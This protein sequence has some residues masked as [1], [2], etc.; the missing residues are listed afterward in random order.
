MRPTHIFLTLLL[1]SPLLAQQQTLFLWPNGNPE[2]SAVVGPEIDPTTDANRIVSGKITI[3]VTNVSKPSLA[4]YSPDPAKN[5]GAAALVFPGGAYIRLAYNI[6]GTEVCDW[7]NSIGMTCVLV[8]YRVPEVGH[9]PE[10]V[11]DLE[12]AQQAMRLTR[13]H[14][15][16]WHID[17]NR[18]GVIGFS[19]GA[20]LAAVLGTHPDFQGK[21]V[22][23]SKIDARP[24]FQMIIYPGW[25][26]GVDGQVSQSLEPTPQTPPTFLLQAENDYTA[27]VESSIVYFQAL[28]D[29]KIP[30]ELHLFTEGG[31]GF[32]L[33]P[34]DLPISHWP[35]LAETWL[36]T[37]H[38]LGP[39]GPVGR[40]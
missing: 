40:P 23:K 31:H 20:H 15:S 38:I 5:N 33:R 27:H 39:S 19:A 37:I 21:N 12:D 24:N 1:V 2:P 29:A 32:G 28:K 30:A 18:I 4:V 17:A 25:T 14:A 13:A 7:L 34:T 36:H 10:N 16:E 6:E 8:K 22:P 26:S 3:R 35:T 11:E 9:Y